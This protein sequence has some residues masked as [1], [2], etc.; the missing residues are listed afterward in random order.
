MCTERGGELPIVASALHSEKDFETTV[1]KSTN[2]AEKELLD[3][4]LNTKSFTF[5]FTKKEK[6]VWQLRERTAW[7]NPMPVEN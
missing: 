3:G 4:I 5:M 7:N 6:D 2:T 1:I